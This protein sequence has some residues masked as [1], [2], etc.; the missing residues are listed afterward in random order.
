MHLD[1]LKPGG[2]L[3]ISDIL[4]T[5]EL[6]AEV[7]NNLALH[8]ACVGGAATV[9]STVAMLEQSGFKD[10]IIDVKEDSKKIINEWITGINAG[11]YIVSAYI[12]AKKPE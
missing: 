7:R 2:R 6:P 11:D 12:E 3:A 5:Q 9:E 1:V 8:S 10:I 4:A